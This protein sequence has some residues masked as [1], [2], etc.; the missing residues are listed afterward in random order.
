MP[1]RAC[2]RFQD[3]GI[4]ILNPALQRIH[5]RHR[6]VDE[7]LDQASL[8]FER[9]ASKV[10]ERGQGTAIE[11]FIGVLLAGRVRPF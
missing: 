5:A 8:E 4:A 7:F 9:T 11:R 3:G 6:L 10:I 1:F 2:G